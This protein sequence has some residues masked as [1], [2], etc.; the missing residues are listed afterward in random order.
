M[1]KSKILSCSISWLILIAI[2]FICIHYPTTTMQE[3]WQDGHF[4]APTHK[5]IVMSRIVAIKNEDK[6]LIQTLNSR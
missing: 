2:A 3:E 5:T 4:I 6:L 1:T